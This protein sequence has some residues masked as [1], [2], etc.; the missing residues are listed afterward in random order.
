MKRLNFLMVMLFTCVFMIVFYQ[1]NCGK[2]RADSDWIPAIDTERVKQYGSWSEASFRYAEYKHL[3]TDENGAALECVFNGRGVVLCMDNNAVPAYGSPN[4]GKLIITIDGGKQ[5]VVYPRVTAKEIAV[6]RNLENGE[7]RLRLEHY[8]EDEMSGCRIIGFRIFTEASGELE[9]AINGEK[10]EYLVDVRAVLTRDEEIVR[11][12]LV[13]NWLTGRCR[14]AGLPPGDDYTL[15]LSAA[16]W[17]SVRVDKITIN[18]G[19]ETKLPPIFLYREDA[20]ENRWINYPALCRTAVRKPGE[21]FRSQIINSRFASGARIKGVMLK[22]S[23]G[24]ATIS[25]ILTF[26]EDSSA[27][28]YYNREVIVN[29]PSEMP[30]GLYDLIFEVSYQG[31]I[32]N[33]VS[34]RSVYIVSN[35]PENPVLLTFGHLDTGAQYQAEY[36]QRLADIANIIAPDIVLNSNAVNPAYISGAL[37]ILDMPY[38]IT[39]GNHQFHGHESWYGEPV[40]IIDYG[41]DICILNFGLPWR[42]DLSKA[43]SLLQSRINARCKIINAYENNAPVE[44]FL[45]RYEISLLHDAHGTGKKVMEIGATPTVR[46]GKVNSSSFRVVR[47]QGNRIISCT[48]KGDEIAPIPFS[49][50]EGPPLR[51]EFFPANDGTNK[52]VKATITNDWEED[53][54]KCRVVFVLPNG[55]Y[56]TNR[57]YIKSSIVSDDEKYVV[58][59][60]REDIPAQ[61]KINITVK[62]K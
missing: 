27:E 23:V 8:S 7:H 26:Q 16:G 13:R 24:P 42:V 35:Y 45:D 20:T 51:V 11:N 2:D 61:S 47:F 50:E 46:V 43:H 54:P 55:E 38:V 21:S 57:G 31:D 59:S 19:S 6:A 18:A 58:L 36:L 12:T 41:S 34:P 39:F 1:I 48:Y 37:S 25:R 33:L 28:F 22:R 44:S 60:V 10:N 15:E 9:F 52:I 56:I 62:P 30:V 32:L 17:K 53:F 49:R 14:V 29:L 4:L 5:Q 3:R 40:G